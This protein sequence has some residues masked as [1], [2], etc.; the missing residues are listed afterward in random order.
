[1]AKRGKFKESDARKFLRE[2]GQL[3][4]FNRF[5]RLKSIK[6][7]TLIISQR[8]DESVYNRKIIIHKQRG[9]TIFRD[10]NSLDVIKT[11]KKPINQALDLLKGRI[12][13]KESI[14][15]EFKKTFRKRSVIKVGDKTREVSRMVT[16]DVKRKAAKLDLERSKLNLKFEIKES[17]FIESQNSVRTKLITNSAKRKSVGSLIVDGYVIKDKIRKRVQARSRGVFFLS[18]K[19]Q[20]DMAF[21][22]A[23]DN[24]AAVANLGTPDEVIVIN[25]WFEYRMDMEVTP[26]IKVR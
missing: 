7:R 21:K 14:N 4:A 18:N 9:K 15:L 10:F 1:M 22:D 3:K 11:T 6:K 2:R 16:K 5:K 23:V 13:R 25:F 24:M 17:R 26:K 19:Q 20:F 12:V 8:L